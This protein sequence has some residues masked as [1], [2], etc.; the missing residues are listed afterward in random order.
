MAVRAEALGNPTCSV[1]SGKL[2]AQDDDL[3]PARFLFHPSM[4]F[5]DLRHSKAAADPETDCA[6]EI[7]SA[8]SRKWNMKARRGEASCLER[9]APIASKAWAVGQFL[10]G[11]HR[12][13]SGDG[14]DR[15]LG[16][17]HRRPRDDRRR[18]LVASP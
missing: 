12:E 1:G 5:D 7:F 14:V 6:G 2:T 11:H 18:R 17:T 8:M 13:Q 3:S 9:K 10:V 4:G 16:G 15:P